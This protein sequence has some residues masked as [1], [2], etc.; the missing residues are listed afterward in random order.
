MNNDLKA[1]LILCCMISPRWYDYLSLSSGT[2]VLLGTVFNPTGME[3]S[4]GMRGKSMPCNFKRQNSKR[5]RIIRAII[6]GTLLSFYNFFWWGSRAILFKLTYIAKFF[7]S[8]ER[9]SVFLF[10]LRFI[11]RNSLCFNIQIFDNVLLVSIGVN[12]S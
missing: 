7:E 11:V 2:Y 5:K 8:A 6:K 12:T 9:G 1:Q 10:S 4:E 3:V